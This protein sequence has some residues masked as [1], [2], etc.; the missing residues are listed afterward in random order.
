MTLCLVEISVSEHELEA[1]SRDVEEEQEAAGEW[2][3]SE[4]WCPGS[5]DTACPLSPLQHT[6]CCRLG[7]VG[8]V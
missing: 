3:C 2:P 5:E 1:E 7:G 8:P 4:E 6:E